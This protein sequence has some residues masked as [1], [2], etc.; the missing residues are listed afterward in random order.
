MKKKYVIS[1]QE[2]YSSV[3][4]YFSEDKGNL[5]DGK[6]DTRKTIGKRFNSVDEAEKKVEDLLNDEHFY[7]LNDDYDVIFSIETIYVKII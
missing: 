5:N 4:L 7:N 2:V 6:Y 1:K 3:S